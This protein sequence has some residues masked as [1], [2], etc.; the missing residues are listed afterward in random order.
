MPHVHREEDRR[1]N[2]HQRIHHDSVAGAA[3][4]I[5]TIL[6]GEVGCG[7]GRQVG[8]GL[9]QHVHQARASCLRSTAR[10]RATRRAR[11]GRGRARSP[12]SARRVRSASNATRG[13]VGVA[14]SRARAVVRDRVPRRGSARWPPACSRADSKRFFGVAAQ[15]R[16]RR[17]RRAPARSSAAAAAALGGPPSAATVDATSIFS[18]SRHAWSGVSARS[19]NRMAPSA[20]TSLAGADVSRR[21][22][23]ARATRTPAFR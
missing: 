18:A 8:R 13:G 7:F 6:L 15:S 17:S 21:P 22:L 1:G 12:D 14:A 19:S 16:G 5:A 11:G 3:D 2:A 4:T 20:Y 10:E 9:E 23:P